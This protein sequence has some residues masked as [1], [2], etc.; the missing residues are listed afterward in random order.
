MCVAAGLPKEPADTGR[1]DEEVEINE[2][3][4]GAGEDDGASQKETDT[5]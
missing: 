3:D 4:E 1:Q 5:E 2:A